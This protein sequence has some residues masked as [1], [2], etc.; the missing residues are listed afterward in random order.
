MSIVD[1]LQTYAS[2][3]ELS[4]ASLLR[5]ALIV[6]SKLGI[7]DV[8]DWINKELSGYG[9]GDVLPASR[10][11]FGRVKARSVHG[12][13]TVGF[14]TTD[15]QSMVSKREVHEP[16][17]QIEKLISREGSLA[18][19][20]SPE[21]SRILEDAF[22][23]ETEFICFLEKSD[24][25]AILDDIRNRVLRWAIALD[26]VGVHGSGLSFTS[27]EKQKA[28]DMTFNVHNGS[29]VIGVAGSSGGQSHV[30]VSSNSSTVTNER[31][32]EYLN[33]IDLQ[34]LTKELE[35]LH[36]RLD[37]ITRKSEDYSV[38]DAVSCAETAA[39]D[40]RPADMAG[41]LASLGEKTHWV[42]DLTK[43]IGLPL[44]AAALKGILGL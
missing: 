24:L 13:L 35:V 2:D 44:L 8:P 28:A 15:L 42:F 39:K 34:K 41:A 14:P 4:A 6:A 40:G 5:K 7:E 9:R 27:H 23:M 31:L 43:E 30:S 26:K 10:I 32:R 1:D 16:V 25:S 22:R 18:Y 12:W 20:F 29:I 37:E 21:Q 3:H 11:I 38:L 36:K 19:G 17:A 33:T